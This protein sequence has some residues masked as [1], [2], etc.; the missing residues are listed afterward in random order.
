MQWVNYRR[1]RLPDGTTSKR[2]YLWHV[3]VANGWHLRRTVIDL[4]TG[5]ILDEVWVDGNGRPRSYTAAAESFPARP[6]RP[7]STATRRSG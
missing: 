4:A 3:E 7:G 1:L 5:E 2:E 6:A